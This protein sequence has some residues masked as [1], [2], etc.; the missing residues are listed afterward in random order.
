MDG[1]VQWFLGKSGQTLALLT[2]ALGQLSSNLFEHKLIISLFNI[3][4]SIAYG[5]FTIFVLVLFIKLLIK[6]IDKDNI[7]LMD[8][9]TRIM[10]GALF[11]NFVFKITPLFYQWVYS[12]TTGLLAFMS[13]A[14]FRS[15]AGESEPI[16]MSI[17][18]GVINFF[19]F[20]SIPG[21]KDD[22]NMFFNLIIAI[23]IVYNFGKCLFQIAERWYQYF[24][25]VMMSI[26]YL[27]GYILGAN[28]SLTS[29]FKQ[30]SS[31]LI[32]HAL[33]VLLLGIGSTFLV[34][35][36]GLPAMFLSCG[37]FIV[38]GKVDKI[39][40]HWGLSAGGDVRGITRSA[41]SLASNVR[42]LFR[43]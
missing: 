19:T 10:I 34:A 25:V 9:F 39:I 5:L 32:T 1:I 14:D 27:P 6:I 31:V 26:F 21:I 16:W 38:A 3:G 24:V 33:Q 43:R 29:W 7:N 36:K 4:Q 17:G 20:N 41:F 11:I 30:L 8:V 35:E 18:K 2:A 12:M 42:M 13:Q 22:G 28:E 37:A 15:V 23:V 40:A